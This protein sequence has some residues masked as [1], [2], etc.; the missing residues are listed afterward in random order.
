MKTGELNLIL[1]Q[2]SVLYKAVRGVTSSGPHY[3]LVINNKPYEKHGVVVSVVTSQI[4]KR[5]ERLT[6]LGLNESSLVLLPQNCYPHLKK[7]SAVDC[8]EISVIPYD[9]LRVYALKDFKSPDFP[10]EYIQ[11][12]VKA[13]INSPKV[14]DEIKDILTA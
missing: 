10:P 3:L 8:N 14:S 12:I 5:R 9:E 11:Q 1:R 2:G 7:E 13:V 4:E 6:R